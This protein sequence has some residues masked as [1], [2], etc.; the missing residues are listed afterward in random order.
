MSKLKQP[1]KVK[2]DLYVIHGWA[3]SVDPWQTTIELLKNAGWRV[4]LLRVPGLTKQ[5]SKVYTIDDY[6]KWLNEELRLAKKPILLGHSNGG[7]ILLNYCLKHPDKIKHLILLNSAGVQPSTKRQF[8]ISFLQTL[9]KMM[10]LLKK[11]EI[12]RNL[13]YKILR[14][15]DYNKAPDNMKA[16][17][18][19]MLDSDKALKENLSQIKAPISFIWG[20]K[21]KITPLK[22]G[23]F[24]KSKLANVINFEVL[25]SV[26]HAPYVTHPKILTQAILKIVTKL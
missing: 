12:I 13:V 16:T 10:F 9:S 20:E 24:L 19:N 21:D 2:Q 15:Q 6:V 8:Y 7:R 3:Y 26:R 4:K 23:Y 22:D 18:S 25:P 14:V 17:L 11:I 1:Q 5:S